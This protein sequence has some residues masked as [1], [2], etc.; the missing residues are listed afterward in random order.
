MK[1]DPYFKPYK[2]VIYT[3]PYKRTAKNKDNVLV[4]GDLHAPFTH[5]EY[6]QFCRHTQE[7]YD[8][9]TV[10]FIGDIAD[11]HY[12]S[13]H[14][15]DPDGFSAG[16]EAT[17]TG[18]QLAEWYYMFP[19]ASVMIGNHDLII[20]RKMYTSGLSR[21]YAKSWNDLFCAPSGWQFLDK[22]IINNV[23]YCHGVSAALKRSQESHISIVQGHLHSLFY[24]QYSQSEINKIF[25]VQTGCGIDDESFAFGYA[26]NFNKKPVLGCSV[27]LNKGT[28]PIIIP[29]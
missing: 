21:R 3:K 16:E 18:L 20:Y 24:I 26:K 22:I 19:C 2:K 15:S 25:S 5:K 8:C 10:I 7:S 23:L 4:I 28:L 9:G 6:L 27:I 29:M 1:L 12:S 14:E 11:F 17:M 13:Y